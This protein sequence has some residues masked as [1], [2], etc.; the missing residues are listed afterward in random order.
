MAKRPISSLVCS[1]VI[2][3]IM[4]WLSIWLIQQRGPCDDVMNN[5]SHNV[6]HGMRVT[7]AKGAIMSAGSRV[8]GKIQPPLEFFQP[9]LTTAQ[10]MHWIRRD[11]CSQRTYQ[12]LMKQA[13]NQWECGTEESCLEKFLSQENQLQEPF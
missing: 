10:I 3:C 1:V 11:Y 8:P 2:I 5:I 6:A 4:G 13:H 7:V 12:Y 9:P